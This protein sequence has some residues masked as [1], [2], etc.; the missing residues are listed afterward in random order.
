MFST[1]FAAL[2]LY[3]AVNKAAAQIELN[4]NAYYGIVIGISPEL[5]EDPR[6]IDAIKVRF[7]L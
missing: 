4:D 3:S 2:L 1:L 5:P 7:Q 6:L